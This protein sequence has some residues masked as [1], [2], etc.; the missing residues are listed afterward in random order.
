MQL[1]DILTRQFTDAEYLE[2]QRALHKERCDKAITFVKKDAG[3]EEL[4]GKM[5]KEAE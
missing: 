4:I 2:H 1:N 3:N 5:K